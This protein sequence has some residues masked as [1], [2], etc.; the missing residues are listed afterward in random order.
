MNWQEFESSLDQGLRKSGPSP[1][2]GPP[3]VL[4]RRRLKTR[5]GGVSKS[6]LLR[7]PPPSAALKSL[8]RRVSMNHQNPVSLY[9]WSTRFR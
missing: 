8:L 5:G 9:P 3:S 7:I 6:K 1:L 2:P 4:L